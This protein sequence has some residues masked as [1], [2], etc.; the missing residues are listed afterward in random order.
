MFNLRQL[1]RL[2]DERVE[3]EQRAARAQR[4]AEALAAQ[5][6]RDAETQRAHLAARAAARADVEREAALLRVQLEA[7]A[8]QRAREGDVAQVHANELARI[9][10]ELTR[11]AARSGTRKLL[12]TTLTLASACAA[13]LWL[14]DARSEASL[15]EAP[16]AVI[17]QAQ[18]LDALQ[19]QLRALSAMPEP[20]ATLQ[21]PSTLQPPAEAQAAAPRPKPAHKPTKQR[22]P[23]THEVGLGED[24]TDP[25]EGL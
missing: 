8:A 9:A 13:A 20:P 25:I 23:Q 1:M 5:R 22:K 18:Q 7:A 17:L 19:M 2:Q 12:V 6:E 24:S 3:Q 11:R 10:D 16:A 14:V 4:E 15:R 21:P